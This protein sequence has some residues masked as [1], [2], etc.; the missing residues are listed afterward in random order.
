MNISVAIAYDYDNDGDQDLFVGG[1]SVPFVYGET[2]QSYLFQNDGK[3]HFKD[4]APPSLAYSGM[5]T[6]AVWAD[7]SGDKR[8]ELIVSGEWMAL[9]IFSYNK[10]KFEELKNTGLN[11]LYGWWESLASADINGDGREDLILGNIGE[12]FYLRPDKESPVKLWL[13]DFDNNG[14]ID[15]FLTR[16]VNGR[17]MPVFLKRE[18]QDQFPFLKKENLKHSDY[19]KKSIQELFGENALKDVQVKLFNYCTSIVAINNGNG[20]FTVKPLPVYVQ[21]S[22]VNAICVS[23]INKDGRQD[24]LLGGN[25]FTFPPQFGRLDASYGHVLINKGSGEFAYMESKQTGIMVKGEVKDIKEI[26]T[27]Q[28]TNFLFTQNDSIPILY[29]LN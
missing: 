16:T 27:R 18:V 1:R 4:V 24:L 19:A 17:D 29:Q 11:D 9:K 7:V 5:I 3:G 22:S 14:T 25:M 13:K 20:S 21:L 28:G 23:D 26:K 15:Q 2:P 8:K 10:G 12:N 6:S